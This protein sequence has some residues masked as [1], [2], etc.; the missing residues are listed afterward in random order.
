MHFHLLLLTGWYFSRNTEILVLTSL[1]SVIPGGQVR[2]C[3]FLFLEEDRHKLLVLSVRKEATVKANNIFLKKYTMWGATYLS[4]SLCL[5]FLHI[6]LIATIYSIL[7]LSHLC[8]CVWSS[9][10]ASRRLPSYHHLCNIWGFL[11]VYC[12][13]RRL[14][15]LCQPHLFLFPH[16]KLCVQFRSSVT[17]QDMELILWMLEDD[18]Q[19][20]YPV[21]QLTPTLDELRYGSLFWPA[22]LIHSENYE[23]ISIFLYV[24]QV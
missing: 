8:Y 5:C 4:L 16:S 2:A 9:F 17:V 15:F 19:A 12:C 13:L 20:Y 18:H 11:C 1:I 7:C 24:K 3:C 6:A 23:I 10:P 14:R 22:L 21:V